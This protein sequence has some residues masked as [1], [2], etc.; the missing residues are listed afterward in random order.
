MR[1]TLSDQEYQIAQTFIFFLLLNASAFTL[2]SSYKKFKK[3]NFSGFKH[4]SL[5]LS[6][7]V[8]YVFA[9]NVTS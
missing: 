2:I 7:S 1:A 6:R 4:H 3:K 5:Q 8:N 9:S